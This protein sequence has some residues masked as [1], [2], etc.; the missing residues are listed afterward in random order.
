[1]C[2]DCGLRRV[3]DR[4]GVVLN[5]RMIRIRSVGISAGR[6]DDTFYD[7][8]WWLPCIRLGVY[9]IVWICAQIGGRASLSSYLG[10][11]RLLHIDSI[12]SRTL[13][14]TYVEWTEMFAKFHRKLF[15][16]VGNHLIRFLLPFC[17]TG[18]N[19]V[20]MRRSLFVRCHSFFNDSSDDVCIRNARTQ[21]CVIVAVTNE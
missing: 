2:A 12:Y 19:S 11:L 13:V 15:I 10:F 20:S 4:V 3:S 9:G 21:T 14:C 17:S 18:L 5:A 8:E 7:R 6:K 16:T 1:M